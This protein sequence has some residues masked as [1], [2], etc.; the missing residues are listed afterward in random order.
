MKI[1]M[2][3]KAALMTALTAVGAYIIIPIGPVPITMQTFFVLISGR[4]LG[5]KYG[6]LSQLAYLLLGAFGLPIFSGGRA[7]LGMLFG[8][9]GGFLISFIIAGWIAANHSSNNKT[10][11][12]IL[13]AAVLS[14]YLIGSIYF[15][16]ITESSLKT[17]LSLTVFPFIPGDFL[18]IIAVLLI[19]PIL[20]KRISF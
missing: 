15:A 4:L 5:H 19:A 8:P 18:K 10:N 12:L 3:I 7:G 2:T 14:N 9:T 13:T 11:F 6:A 17:A 16:F 20:E 1:D